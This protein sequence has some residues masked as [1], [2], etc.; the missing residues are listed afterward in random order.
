MH[1]AMLIYFLTLDFS[2]N[3]WKNEEYIF[4]FDVRREWGKEEDNILR[5]NKFK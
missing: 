3:I 1:V 4:K 2:P 5:N